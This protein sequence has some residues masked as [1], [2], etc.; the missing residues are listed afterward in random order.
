MIKYRVNGS[1][2]IEKFEVIKE[3]EKLITYIDKNGREQR[4]AKISTLVSWHDSFEDAQSF[5]MDKYHKKIGH[6]QYQIEYFE[7]K[8]RNILLMENK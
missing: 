8:M 3:T 7:K 6:C 4:E 5:L 1:D 2:Q